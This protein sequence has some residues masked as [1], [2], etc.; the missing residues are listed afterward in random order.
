[1]AVSRREV[2][3]GALGV[4]MGA[5]LGNARARTPRSVCLIS[6]PTNLGLRLGATGAQPGTWKMPQVLLNAGLAR[7]IGASRLDTVARIPYHNEPQIGTRI[8]NG[9]SI[10]SFSLDLAHKVSNALRAGEFPVVLGGDCSVLL[11][12][13]LGARWAGGRGLIH[14][15]GHSDFFHPGNYDTKVRL[16]SVAG[17]D[18]ALA[19]GRGEVLLT[20]WPG[21]DGPLVKDED[22]I[23][24]GERDADDPDYVTAGY[25][26]ILRT[27]ITRVPIQWVRREGLDTALQKVKARLEERVLHNAWLHI[28]LDVLD[29]SILPAVDSPGSPG[30]TFA[31]LSQLLS[32][33][34]RTEHIAGVNLTI[35]DPD[36]DPD[37]RCAPLLVQCLGQGIADAMSTQR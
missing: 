7:A 5:A 18:L 17:R 21:I 31:E 26:D 20:Q 36:L 4:C 33:L 19:T 3:H 25:G 12:A 6:A 11:G 37:R 16:G 23:Q 13:L 30:L 24:V 1:M 22:A 35:Y 2:I 27:E 32:A 34:I 9:N 14:V 10:R 15:D 29:Q 8:R 28:D